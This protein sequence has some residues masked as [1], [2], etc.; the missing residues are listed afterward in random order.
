MNVVHVVGPVDLRLA[1]AAPALVACLGLVLNRFLV[2]TRDDQIGRLEHRRHAH[3]E[4][5]VEID[6]PQG[7][8]LAHRRALLQD[9]RALVQAVRGTED[10]EPGFGLAL[11][12]GPVDRRWA[13]ELGQQ[14]RMIL[15]GA[16]L[17]NIDEFLRGELQHE[18]HDADIGFRRGHGLNRL[19]CAQGFELMHLEP[20]CLGRGA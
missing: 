2:L 14:R 17:R 11:D 4:Q 6:R 20:L 8:V 15:N 9:H 10:G 16:V 3:R 5:P 7:V 18:G 1:L 12:D 19:G 13:A